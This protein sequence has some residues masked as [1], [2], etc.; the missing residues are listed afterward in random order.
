IVPDYERA[1]DDARASAR[2]MLYTLE[3]EPIPDG[4]DEEFTRHATTFYRIIAGF[5]PDPEKYAAHSAQLEG[6][7]AEATKIA[8]RRGHNAMMMSAWRR[9]GKGLDVE[10]LYARSIRR[11]LSGPAGADD[12]LCGTLLMAAL[13]LFHGRHDRY[14]DLLYKLAPDLLEETP[15]DPFSGRVYDYARN[16]AGGYTL[17][18]TG[19]NGLDDGGDPFRG[20]DT[21]FM[22]EGYAEGLRRVES[23]NAWDYYRAALALLPETAAWEGLPYV[24]SEASVEDVDAAVADA[25]DALAVLRE[26]LGKP[27]RW[28]WPVTRE[29]ALRAMKELSAARSM[30]RLLRVETWAHQVH[31]NDSAALASCIDALHFSVDLSTEAPPMRALT[32]WATAQI[33][34]AA[35][36]RILE[37]AEDSEAVA[38]FLDQMNGLRDARPT[39]PQTISCL[40]RD[41]WARLDKHAELLVTRPNDTAEGILEAYGVELR[42][43]Q[44]DAY[45][46]LV[47]AIFDEVADVA[48]PGDYRATHETIN[49]L[50]A[51]ETLGRYA[52]SEARLMV[53]KAAESDAT[54]EVV[55]VAAALRIHFLENGQYP[56]S[57][58]GLAPAILTEVPLDPCS[59]EEL[60]YERLG[61]DRCFVYSV[62]WDMTDERARKQFG[63]PR[64]SGDARGA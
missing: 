42:A 26:G 43:N 55:R 63:F 32:A 21:V 61:P 53:S 27:F 8:R 35:A 49:M 25:A 37:T 31:G 7:F 59:G 33:G 4:E 40:Q 60:A 14:P 24:L 30:A 34:T 56:E 45:R 50:M 52:L 16:D 62:G 46:Q 12:Q 41:V 6:A 22:L 13:Q 57:L 44:F 11:G 19:E 36:T 5:D 1:V 38:S 23:D 58:A 20:L 39:L 18:G 47:D 64:W 10:L 3:G 15:V 9:A 17:Y 48:A 2:R 28:D 54:F 29:D 51:R